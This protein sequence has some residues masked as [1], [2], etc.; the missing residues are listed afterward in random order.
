MSTDSAVLMMIDRSR[1]EIGLQYTEAFFDLVS[2][3]LYI[4]YLCFFHVEYVGHYRI[5]AIIFFL[6]TDAFLIQKVTALL[7]I[8]FNES[9]DIIRSLSEI[10]RIHCLQ[11]LLCTLN[12]TV[13]YSLLV[14]SRLSRIRNDQSLFQ[15]GLRLY[16][17]CISIFVLFYFEQSHIHHTIDRYRLVDISI[18]V[19]TVLL[20]SSVK[21]FHGFKR[22]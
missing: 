22:S 3:Y 9:C 11:K 19:F 16:L 14:F 5:E 10:F 12:L 21:V 13:P 6:F 8:T 20:K 2:S 15:T 17:F 4:Q 7:F 18:I 1:T